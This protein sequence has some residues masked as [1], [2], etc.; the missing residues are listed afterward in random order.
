MRIKG[1]CILIT[2]ASRGI[3]RAIAIEAARRGAS[4]L[5]L[6]SRSEN[7]MKEVANEVLQFGCK[8]YI[9]SVDLSSKDESRTC[10]RKISDQGLSPDILVNNAGLGR[11]LFL[12]ETPEDEMEQMLALP[13]LSS[14][15][16]TRFFL[17]GM[18]KRKQGH[19]AFVNSP[20]SEIAWPGATVYATSRAGLKG[21]A[22]ALI[23]DLQGSG[24]GVTHFISGKVSSHYF[25]ANP[26]SEERLPGISKLL[27][28]L[29]PE[30][31]AVSFCNAVESGKKRK[32]IPPL[33]W[34]LSVFSDWFPGMVKFI[35]R[36]TGYSRDKTEGI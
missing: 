20:A 17:P 22:E 30:E 36:Q 7:E 19:V 27:R 31:V 34:V 29:S 12:E 3:G 33:L 23:A 9:F 21:F 25:D 6:L 1:R 10:F 24:V 2:G 35:V 32:I 8:T 14:I 15:R 18:L 5:I 28:T 11:W 26:G 13:L 16:I 4:D